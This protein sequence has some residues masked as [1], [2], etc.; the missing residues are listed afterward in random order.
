LN[1]IRNDDDSHQDL[2]GCHLINKNMLILPQ[3]ALAG[4]MRA[5][6]G[7]KTNGKWQNNRGINL[8]LAVSSLG[9]PNE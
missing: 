1:S 4:G 6:D 2:H 5:I 8:N 9:F 7:L 3:S